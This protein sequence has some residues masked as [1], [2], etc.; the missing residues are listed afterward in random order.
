MNTVEYEKVKNLDYTDYCKYLQE[1]YGIGLGYYFTKSW[2]KNV[3]VTRTSE[4][5]FVHHIFENIAPRLSKKEEAMYCPYEFQA[6]EVLV[7]CDFLEHLLLHILICEDPDT[8]SEEDPYIGVRGIIS[9]I[10]PELNDVYS[11]WK[12]K[13]EW[14]KRTH[15]KIINDKDVYLKLLKRAKDCCARR[16]EDFTVD[17][18]LRSLNDGYDSWT[19]DNNRKIYNEIKNL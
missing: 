5:L 17:L 1:K 18:F 8:Y 7:Y 14:R 2:N 15:E 4:G 10:I 9:F 12:A 19:N 6:P 11:G 13:Q 16:Y 3:K